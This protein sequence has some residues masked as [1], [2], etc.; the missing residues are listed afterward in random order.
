MRKTNNIGST[1]K[2]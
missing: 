2:V 1:D